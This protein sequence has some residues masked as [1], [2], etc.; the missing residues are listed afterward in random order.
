M[1]V[2][3]VPSQALPA[4]S[5]LAVQYGVSRNVVREALDL[6]RRE[7]LVERIP[8]VG[9]LPKPQ[10]IGQGL[11]CLK[12]L[13]ESVV[14]EHLSVDNVVLAAREVPANTFVASKLGVSQGSNVLFVER[15]RIVDGLPLSLDTSYLRTE[16]AKA[17]LGADLFHHDL[18]SVSEVL[19]QRSLG[20]AEVT[21][22]AVAA[23]ES[24]AGY[25]CVSA[26]SPLILMQRMV[27][28]NDGT[29]FDLEVIRYRGDRFYLCTTLKR[30]TDTKLAGL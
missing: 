24:T 15:L 1:S 9:T 2:F 17:F 4:E 3:G 26:G 16:I 12:G 14:G 23:D 8:G 10:K 7:G 18:F 28:L 21:A 11:D 13:A 6:L 22:E 30:T 29:P 5:N 25:L 19:Q 20:W 27:Y